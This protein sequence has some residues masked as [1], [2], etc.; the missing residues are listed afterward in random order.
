MKIFLLTLLSLAIA[1]PSSSQAYRFPE[2]FLTKWENAQHYTLQVARL[3]PERHYTYQPFA[4]AR[5]FGEQMVHISEAMVYHAGLAL[6]I[7]DRRGSP[8]P[9]DKEVVIQHLR[10]SY[11]L[12]EQQARAMNARDW[13]EKVKFWDGPTSRRKILTFTAD[14]ITHHRGQAVVYLRMKGIKPPSYVG[15]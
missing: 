3:M 15:W 4:G 7:T 1:M 11:T 2:E 12:V 10:E 9:A 13:E 14:H 5:T 6:V 8:N